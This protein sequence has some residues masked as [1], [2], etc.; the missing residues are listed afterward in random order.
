MTYFNYKLSVFLIPVFIFFGLSAVHADINLEESYGGF[1]GVKSDKVS[2]TKAEILGFDT[3]YG[4]YLAYVYPGSPAADAGLRIFDYIIEINGSALKKS[5]RLGDVLSK[6]GPGDLV[7]ISF[8]RNGIVKET[9]CK[10]A[11]RS[12]IKSPPVITSNED[13]FLGIEQSYSY[14]YD[15]V[16]GVKVN[17]IRGFSADKMG[18]KPGDIIFS[19]DGYRMIDW[20]DIS[21]ILDAKLAGDKTKIVYYRDGSKN[22][23]T[24]VLGSKSES[25]MA[26]RSVTTSNV[27]PKVFL[28]VNPGKMNASKAKNMGLDN[29]HGFYIKGTVPG[30]VADR[31]GLMAMD[32]IYGIDSYRVGEDQNL[33]NILNRYQPGDEADIHIIR[34]GKAKI[35]TVKMEPKTTG[36]IPMIVRDACETPYLGVKQAEDKVSFGLDIILVDGMPG[37]K[38]G[39][40]D[41]DAITRING[42]YIVDW[43]DLKY[44]HSMYSPG[45]K[46]EI[47]V[48]RDG[49]KRTFN[50]TFV[51]K[52]E[53]KGC[54]TCTCGE[55]LVLNDVSIEL[56]KLDKLDKLEEIL[57]ELENLDID[58]D[59]NID[60]DRSMEGGDDRV[61]KRNN[62][63]V[64]IQN[65]LSEN[66]QV[67]LR[68]YF[69][70][71]DGSPKLDVKEFSLK[72]LNDNVF[73]GIHFKLLEKGYLNVKVATDSGRLIYDFESS[74]FEGVFEDR[75]DLAQ[76]D[77]TY[78]F[79]IRQNGKEFA[80]KVVLK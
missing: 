31:S 71:G 52:K 30:S 47:E 61:A 29:P 75:I 72:P 54:E 43:N 38:L 66:D 55:T 65:T 51:S 33:G 12:D 20:D 15:R 36:K 1:L 18:L 74:D 11:R 21:I 16:K 68:S 32:Y 53:A 13:A 2:S 46:M 7:K 37:D 24:G 9:R 56:D 34:K 64:E 45:D 19:I 41:Y 44:L 62:R 58:I 59:I 5:N 48:F 10:L 42:H 80:K 25:R 39:L 28:G 70:K 17:V 27:S 3:A 63:S 49:A 79:F 40:K 69:G 60:S 67:K 14:D 6:Y 57:E 8:I 35:I 26:S 73:Y 77:D 4:A 22:V 23:T 78:Y 76:E 50:S